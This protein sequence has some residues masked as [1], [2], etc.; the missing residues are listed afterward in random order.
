MYTYAH[1]YVCMS[2]YAPGDVVRILKCINFPWDDYFQFI[3]SFRCVFLDMYI[4]TY[5]KIW[6]ACKGM[7]Y[8]Y[9]MVI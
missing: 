4:H 5:T 6:C 3:H 8:E 1:K 9:I 7:K 2:K